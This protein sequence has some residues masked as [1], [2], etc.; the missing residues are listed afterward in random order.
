VESEI[1]IDTDMETPAS[2]SQFPTAEPVQRRS[3]TTTVIAGL[4]GT[5]CV[6]GVASTLTGSSYQPATE[7]SFVNDIAA[8]EYAAFVNFKNEHNREYAD[9]SEERYRTHVFVQNMRKVHAHNEEHAAGKH[10]WTMKLNHFADLTASEF[11]AKFTGFK[12]KRNT[13]LH[14]Q[15][16]ADLSHVTAPDS[17][18]WVS[19]GA[20]TPVKNQGSCGSCW[21]FSTTGALEGLHYIKTGELISLSEQ[22]LMDCSKDEGNNSC[23]GG[24]MDY[25]FEFVIKEGICLESAYP[26]EEEDHYT[27]KD[28]SCDSKM[29]ITGYKDV[30]HNEQALMAAISQ[31][32]V[33]IAI[34]AD[35]S[36]FQF[37]S[38]GVLT[39][40]CG[41]Q[42]DHGVLAVGYGQEN[43]VNYWKVKNSWGPQWGDEGYIKL[44]R[45]VSQDGGQCGILLSASYPTA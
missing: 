24:L 40:E 11:K 28:S 13:Y 39:S 6:L 7:K 12:G 25:A 43:G 36:A 29:K 21:S 3:M 1:D 10:T 32:P 42:L 30:D 17:I 16:V 19:K 27:C 15:N 20:V 14:A 38:S 33:S 45:D 8:H 22:E 26:Y 41:T 2:Y 23:E 31:Q 5:A 18:D 9:S 37:Y 34:E 44:S 4:L 35:Q